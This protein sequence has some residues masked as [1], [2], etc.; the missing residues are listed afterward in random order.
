FS[1]ASTQG[2]STA[3]GGRRRHHWGWVA[4]NVI[5]KK[6]IPVNAIQRFREKV[7]VA[8]RVANATTSSNINGLIVRA[9]ARQLPFPDE[10]VD[11]VITSPPY[12][13]MIDYVLANR[14][15]YLWM[16]WPID[17]DR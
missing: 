10:S 17:E 1:C 2:A 5:P 13:G 4:D 11:L 12:L 3:T 9:D 14:L 8:I 7:V 6:L 16:N 15:T